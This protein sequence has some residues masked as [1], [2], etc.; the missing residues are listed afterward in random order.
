MTRLVVEGKDC[1]PLKK[2][3]SN[4]LPSQ[5][6]SLDFCKSGRF[7]FESD[8]NCG[9]LTVLAVWEHQWHQ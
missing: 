2:T 7:E 6:E 5:V 9:G 4:S 8:T 3:E 1:I